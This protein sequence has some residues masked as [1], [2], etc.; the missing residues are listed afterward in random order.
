MLDFFEQCVEKTLT[1][2]IRPTAPGTESDPLAFSPFLSTVLAGL[3]A[4]LEKATEDPKPL[5][6]FVRRLVLG[7]IGRSAERGLAKRV[8]E[9][10]AEALGDAKD[11]RETRE[12][13]EDFVRAL[14]ERGEVEGS[15]EGESPVRAN[16]FVKV[17]DAPES[18]AL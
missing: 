17:Q 4:A 6:A 11:T 2:P 12:V 10:L 13:V 5:L 3:P 15:G 9:A 16:I 18:L 8:V 14:E 7:F 1:A